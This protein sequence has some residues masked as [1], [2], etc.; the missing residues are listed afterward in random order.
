MAVPGK[1]AHLTIADARE[2]AITIE[3]YFV[4]PV[5]SRRLIYQRRELGRKLL[6]D[7]RTGVNSWL[8]RFYFGFLCGWAFFFFGWGFFLRFICYLFRCAGFLTNIF[9]S[10]SSTYQC[11][12][13]NT[14][15]LLTDN[16]I[17]VGVARSLISLLN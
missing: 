1:Q 5:T 7:D 9:F 8:C 17:I 14:L 16:V 11:T 3:F 10:L 2:N 4:Q 13:D 12:A 6:G 15:G